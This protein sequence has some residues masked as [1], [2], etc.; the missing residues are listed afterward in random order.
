MIGLLGKKI[1]MTQ[2]FSKEGKVVPVT[3]IE[4]GPC[5][6]VQ[7]K[8]A[9]KDGYQAVQLGYGQGKRNLNRP[10]R[11][12]FKKVNAEPTRF[13]REFR[14]S[15][16][17]GIEIGKQLTLE[18][19]KVGD[20]VD[21]AGM[22]KGRGFQG[23]VKRWSWSGG[24]AAHGS[25]QHR[26]PGSIGSNTTPGRVLRRHRMPGHM[27]ADRRTVQNLEV[28]HLDLPQ[29][30]L[31]VRGAVPGAINSLLEIR[32]AVKNPAARKKVHVEVEH[33]E[34]KKDGMTG[35]VVG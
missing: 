5:L 11:G 26:E 10:M 23:G 25:M 17:T 33:K 13:L 3:V 19:F 22:T 6:V 30:L 28:V 27:G 4:G 7:V 12:H 29:D 24:G 18:Q 1:G 8:N 32:P 35:K 9:E 2:V 31:V 16:T 34:K 20:F 21:V 14:C 15:N